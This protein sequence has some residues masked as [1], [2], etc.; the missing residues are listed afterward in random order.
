M[1]LHSHLHW[2]VLALVTKANWSTAKLK[3]FLESRSWKNWDKEI[4]PYAYNHWKR[5]VSSAAKYVQVQ[6]GTTSSVRVGKTITAGEEINMYMQ[7]L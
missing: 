3:L 6:P 4:T 2:P 5:V 1:H 7:F